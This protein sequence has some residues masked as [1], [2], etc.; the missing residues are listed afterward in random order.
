MS[1]NYNSS[2]KLRQII[3][4]RVKLVNDIGMSSLNE[5]DT[6]S[7]IIEPI[8]E[9]IGWDIRDPRI[10]TREYHTVAGTYVDYALMVDN[11]PKLLM[12]AKPLGSNLDHDKYTAQVVSYANNEGVG[13][14]VLTDGII[15]RIFKTD[16]SVKGDRKL[17]FEINLME[18]DDPDAKVLE[19]LQLLS[20]ESVSRGELHNLGSQMF[21]D[22]KVWAILE[23]ILKTQD[24]ALVNILQRKMKAFGVRAPSA[25][26]RESLIRFFDVGS[27][28]IP[29]IKLSG[30]STQNQDKTLVS[31]E[32]VSTKGKLN[33]KLTYAEKLDKWPSTRQIHDTLVSELVQL[34]TELIKVELTER[35][36][37]VTV[38]V[39]GNY[40]GA[41]EAQRSGIKA[42]SILD[43]DDATEFAPSMKERFVDCAGKNRWSGGITEILITNESDV[44]AVA[45]LLTQTQ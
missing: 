26:I 3:S 44:A 31:A 36:N 6:K 40:S 14:C 11:E 28:T 21:F 25:E 1:D 20:L 5:S 32:C 35:K 29:H 23:E 41:F 12:E 45:R 42:R 38:Y 16:E 13:W 7:T 37:M 18:I 8:L 39:N 17:A 9:E 19:R 27:E 30:T 33:G 34:S 2:D 24:Q 4:E 43:I 10:V 22:S 15:W